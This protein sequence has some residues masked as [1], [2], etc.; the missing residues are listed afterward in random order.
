MASVLF[1]EPAIYQYLLF[2]YIFICCSTD[3]FRLFF[4]STSWIQFTNSLTYS[5]LTS[6]IHSLSLLYLSGAL[7]TFWL[8]LWA[9]W[10]LS[11]T[12]TKQWYKSTL[13]P[14][15]TTFQ[16]SSKFKQCQW[17]IITWT[18]SQFYHQVHVMFLYVCLANLHHFLIYA[19]S[20][21]L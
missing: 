17:L 4:S 12:I 10:H 21:S 9:I 11:R 19:L 8:F 18:G 6:F 5:C 15:Y 16:T 1:F 13:A 20:F 3:H 2:T 7:G 14:L